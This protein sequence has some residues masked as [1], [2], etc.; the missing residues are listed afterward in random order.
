MAKIFLRVSKNNPIQTQ[1]TT[2][3]PRKKVLLK[4]KKPDVAALDHDLDYNASTYRKDVVDF[5]N[6]YIDSPNYKARLL[7]QGYNEQEA[8]D[9]ISLR[10][11]N[12]SVTDIK[13]QLGRPTGS[14]YDPKDQKVYV[15]PLQWV[16][17]PNFSLRGLLSH[18]Y[19]HVAGA[20]H[21]LSPK[22]PSPMRLSNKEMDEIESRNKLFKIKTAPE[23]MVAG[24]LHDR[25]GHEGKADMDA[26]RYMM[27]K[28]G[29][30]NTGKQDFNLELLNI[31]KKKYSGDFN[32]ARLFK[33][34]SDQD[35]IWLMNNIAANNHKES[36]LV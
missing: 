24:I 18:E 14:E 15:D 32:V 20:M 12:L 1:Q 8:N 13:K 6:N 3:A 36:D 5:F 33:N 29:L 27:Y 30:Y 25:A 26:L 35:I 2:P 34:F 9:A 10:K 11:A 28:D 7:K 17:Y 22:I 21:P 31:A 4:I 16:K 19:S 23:N